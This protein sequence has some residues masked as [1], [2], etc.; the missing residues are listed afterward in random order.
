MGVIAVR[1]RKREEKGASEDS[2]ENPPLWPLQGGPGVS[3]GGP[4]RRET[5]RGLIND[6]EAIVFI[7]APHQPGKR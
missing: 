7:T 6:G 2:A 5:S 4:S 3:D 1:R